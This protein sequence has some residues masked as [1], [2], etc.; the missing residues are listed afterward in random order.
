MKLLYSH[1]QIMERVQAVADQINKDYAGKKPLLVGVLKGATVFMAHLLVRLKLDVEMDFITVSSYKHG[2]ESGELKLVQDL[3][4][5]A[6]GKDILLVEDI[7]DSGKTL[8]FVYYYLIARG[9]RSVQIVTFLNKT[10]AHPVKEIPNPSYVCFEYAEKPFV[11][12]FGF[13][14]R[15]RWRNLDGVYMMDEEDK[16]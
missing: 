8:K 16:F 6:A 13:D 4:T 5:V 12:G 11:I 14:Y 2:A 10:I 7:I 1:D 15:E 3:D 9:A